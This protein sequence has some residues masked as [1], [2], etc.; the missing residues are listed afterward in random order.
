MTS[1]A[2]T[3]V[4]SEL[5]VQVATDLAPVGAVRAGRA[6]SAVPARPAAGGGLEFRGEGVVVTVE[7]DPAPVTVDPAGGRMS[8]PL[9]LAHGESLTVRLRCRVRTEGARSAGTFDPRTRPRLPRPELACPDPRLAA[10]GRTGSRRPRRTAAVRPGHRLRDAARN[11]A[12]PLRG[13]R[14]PVVPHVVRPRLV[15]GGADAAAGGHRPRHVD[16][17]GAG[18]PAGQD[19][20]TG[21]RGAARQDPARDTRRRHGRRPHPA[22]ALLRQH[23]RDPAVRGAA[24]RGV[25]VGRRPGAGTRACPGSAAVPAVGRAGRGRRRVPALR[26]HHRYG[27]GQ[28]GVEGLERLDPVGGRQRWP[29]RRSRCA[30]H[31]PTPTR[32]R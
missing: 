18:A 31:R 3:P 32:P 4:V 12:G 7:A 16:A 24:G 11:G 28:P 1:A 10:G 13:R 27:A 15:V 23:R 6:A 30:R 5:A 17:A 25:A 21:H 2:Q 29:R 26:R 8:W 19:R 20:A 9:D 22:V 14:E